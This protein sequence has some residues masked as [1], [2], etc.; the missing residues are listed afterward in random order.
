MAVVGMI[1][2][3]GGV[4]NGQVIGEYDNKRGSF[5]CIDSSEGRNE[6][7]GREW[8]VRNSQIIKGDD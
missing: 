5:R 2:N 3:F 4:G 1:R 8:V 6:G 7:G